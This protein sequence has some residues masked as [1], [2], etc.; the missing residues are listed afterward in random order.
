[1][2]KIVK[3]LFGIALFGLTIT[4]V[5]AQTISEKTS[6]YTEDKFIIGSTR[7]DNSEIITA[8]K[9]VLATQNETKLNIALGMPVKEAISK[10]VPIY[11]YSYFFEEW[12]VQENGKSTLIT[13]EEEIKDIEDNL[14]IFFVNNEEK[15]IE[16]PYEGNVT[17]VT[18]G[19]TY[20]D[21]KFKVPATTFNFEFKEDGESHIVYTETSDE[22]TLDYGSF[23]VAAKSDVEAAIGPTQ[24]P[25]LNAAIAAAKDGETIKLTKNANGD[26]II[27]NKNIT[28][29]LNAFTYTIDG[30]LVGSNGTTT[31]GLQLLK[32]NNVTIKNGTITL[33]KDAVRTDGKTRTATIL[34]QNYSN[35]TL[36][37]VTL[38]GATD[39]RYVASNNNGTTLIKNSTINAADTNTALDLYYWPEMGYKNIE[40]NVINSTIN[41]KVEYAGDSTTN[42]DMLIANSVLTI[43]ADTMTKKEITAPAGYEWENNNGINLLVKYYVAYIENGERYASLEEAVNDAKENDTVKLH[44]DSNGNGI[45]INKDITIDLNKFTYTIDGTLVGSDN[46]KTNGFQLLKDNNVT[47]KNG[48][49]TLSQ[50]AV[51]GDG[52][53]RTA[54]ILIQNYSN[55]TLE[56]ATINGATDTWYVVSHNNSNVL[57]KNSIVNAQGEHKSLAIYYWP[58]AGYGKIEVNVVNSMIN[59]K[60]GYS[61]DSSTT[62]ETLKENISLTITDSTFT[63]SNVLNHAANSNNITILA[64]PETAQ[65]SI[66]NAVKG[67]TIELADGNYDL[68]IIDYSFK[69]VTA[70]SMTPSNPYVT[71]RN[72]GNFTISGNGES[73]K[74]NGIKI[75]D[76]HLT[77]FD[78]RNP[79]E[80][81]N[82]HHVSTDSGY[83][84]DVLTIKNMTLSKPLSLSDLRVTANKVV[85]ENVTFDMA[86]APSSDAFS[87]TT[88]YENKIKEVVIKNS[89]FKNSN[90]EHVVNLLAQGNKEN[91]SNTNVTIE[92]NKFYGGI[93]AIMI[94]GTNNGNHGGNFNILNNEF[95]DTTDRAIR[96]SSALTTSSIITLTGNTFTNVNPEEK[97]IFK[98]DGNREA[99]V[100]EN[101]ITNGNASVYDKSTGIAN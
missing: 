51:R 25:S 66:N 45:I 55:L 49:I 88:Y 89:T 80:I 26:G 19:V 52:K 12:Y 21:G 22:T 85:Y 8:D 95:K 69:D 9:V 91:N 64:N 6:A 48:T 16:Y 14:N 43:D 3:I 31:N 20:E 40:V 58:S 35:L 37:G 98:T 75:N 86:A 82:G 74:V 76:Y 68:L 4:N 39:T 62:P 63:D 92:N 24:Y 10:K 101:N 29:D 11:S 93:R 56:G 50:D 79:L 83:V 23:E 78:G 73:T 96:I 94:A 38:N 53:T 61:G 41:G 17:N 1:M 2:K 36:D 32:D 5:N 57:V 72:L 71:T 7:F 59:G 30:K 84:F 67:T 65:Q 100:F 13:D 28:I 27:I 54:T 77:F 70:G 18:D 46:S 15:I 87:L 44:R 34:V 81:K 97:E 42:P 47:I 33:S 99:V 90:A 60:I